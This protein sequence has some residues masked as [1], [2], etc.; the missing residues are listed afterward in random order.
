M[1]NIE[2][3]ASVPDI[4]FIGNMTLAETRQQVIDIYYDKYKSVTGSAPVLSDA[5]PVKLLLDT[6]ALLHYQ[7]LQR[8][9]QRG[10]AELLK[11]SYGNYLDQLAAGVGLDRKAATKATA[12][13]RF[14]L[15]QTLTVKTG[16]PAGTRVCTEGS[17][18]FNTTDYAEIP[19]GTLEIET[20]V[21]A[22]EAGAKYSNLAIGAINSLVD[23]IAYIDSVSNTSISTYGTDAESDD[24]L[25]RRIYLAPS[26]YSCAGPW[27]A[28]KYWALAFRSDI[29][30]I[31]VENPSLNVVS[32]FFLLD[33][34]IIP[35]KEDIDAM[36]E[37]FFATV[38]RPLTDAVTCYA[39]EE[40]EYQI[41]IK[42]Y[43][44]KSNKKQETY[45]KADIEDAINDYKLWQ[46]TLGRDVNPDEL[47]KLV[48]CAGAKRTVVTAPSYLSIPSNKVSKL[49]NCVVEYGG[50]EDD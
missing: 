45:I 35:A 34:G 40:V 21:Q 39:P 37:Y 49:T 36:T 44:G 38:P 29:A 5:D 25:T 27:D 23:P 12:T 50:I 1:S 24:D 4:D 9:N 19:A 17:L 18:Y 41:A 31:D 46:R 30:D 15:S 2:E 13:V 8:I 26:V 11:T 16:I 6:M 28:Y 33:N 48:L 3:L 14:T 7:K 42:Y 32:I 10:K 43:I 47:N 22:E 20:T